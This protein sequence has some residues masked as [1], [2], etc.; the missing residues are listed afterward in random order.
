MAFYN[1]FIKK[2]GKWIWFVKKNK[3]LIQLKNTVRKKLLL[4]NKVG[5]LVLYVVCKREEVGRL[6]GSRQLSL[7]LRVSSVILRGSQRTPDKYM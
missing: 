5:Q 6:V 3:E 2:I 7:C 1:Q 4:N